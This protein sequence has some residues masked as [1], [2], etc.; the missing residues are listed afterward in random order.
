MENLA[1]T[2]EVIEALE[3]YG[4]IW[5]SVDGGFSSTQIKTFSD[6]TDYYNYE[7]S[8]IDYKLFLHHKK[9]FRP[10]YFIALN[11][12]K[13]PDLSNDKSLD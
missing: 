12:R 13:L 10:N 8:R 4:Y 5:L 11:G 6:F 3:K 1:G 9:S 2:T 7:Q